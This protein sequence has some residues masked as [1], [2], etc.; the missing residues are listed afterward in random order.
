MG[1]K[2]CSHCG[3]FLDDDNVCINCG[4]QK[5]NKKE[6]HKF[7]VAHEDE[8]RADYQKLGRQATLRKWGISTTT[9][10]KLT[11]GIT[12]AVTPAEIIADIRE[13]RKLP[14]LQEFWTN[15]LEHNTKLSDHTRERIQDTLDLID[16]LSKL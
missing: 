4:R 11:R 1:S 7:I 2:L 10:H 8:I 16:S 9:L 6:K 12:P 14:V 3:G 5:I 15:Y 13:S